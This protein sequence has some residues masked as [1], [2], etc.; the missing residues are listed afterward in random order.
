MMNDELKITLT[1]EEGRKIVW[2][3]TENYHIISDEII[4]HGRWSILHEAIVLKVDEGN[5]YQTH[6]SVGATEY[7]DES[8]YEYGDATFERVTPVQT[9]VTKYEK[10]ESENLEVE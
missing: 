3:E 10:V 4:D 8:P 6:Y 5:F 2:G 9:T 1:G 7:Q